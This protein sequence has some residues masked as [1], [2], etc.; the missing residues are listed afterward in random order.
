[1]SETPAEIDWDQEL[2]PEKRYPS[3]YT[4]VLPSSI[5]ETVGDF[6]FNAV[7]GMLTSDTY[8][9][10]WLSDFVRGS[11]ST[12]PDEKTEL[13][14]RNQI[15]EGRTSV[16]IFARATEE[17]IRQKS[18]AVNAVLAG[19]SYNVFFDYWSPAQ[20]PLKGSVNF[21]SLQE[22]PGYILAETQLPK[23]NQLIGFPHI[24]LERY[25]EGGS[26]IDLRGIV[27]RTTNL[28]GDTLPR[29]IQ[30][31]L[32]LKAPTVFLDA[33]ESIGRY[34]E[35]D[36]LR[37]GFIYSGRVK[38]RRFSLTE[39][40]NRFTEEEKQYVQRP[41]EQPFW[42]ELN[43]IIQTGEG[44]G[45]L[46]VDYY[47]NGFICY[48]PTSKAMTG[49]IVPSQTDHINTYATSVITPTTTHEGLLRVRREAQDVVKKLGF[50]EPSRTLYW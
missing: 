8:Y 36:R 1:M 9:Q 41:K 50:P 10:K 22:Y 18:I 45:R 48:D 28:S 19:K 23:I 31:M 49:K 35:L 16:G 25:V 24:I 42:F 20:I 3:N 34:S 40:F 33:M 7:L 6:V 38:N 11:T 30:D 4:Y 37:A 47:T 17:A 44:S 12:I 14:V 46:H 26:G 15:D 29:I 39:T 43:H 2:G 5:L 13:S 27:A 32:D 21:N